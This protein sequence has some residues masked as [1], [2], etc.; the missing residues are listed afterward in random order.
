MNHVGKRLDKTAKVNFKIYYVENWTTNHYKTMI[1]GQLKEYNMRYTFL[2]KSCTE[3][4]SETIPIP[5]FKKIKIERNSGL[6]V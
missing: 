2:G 3:C 1:L 4:G 5:F 6:T